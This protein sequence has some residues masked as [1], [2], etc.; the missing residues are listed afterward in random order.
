MTRRAKRHQDGEAFFW[1]DCQILPEIPLPEREFQF[2]KPRRWRFDFAWPK[3]MLAV[4]IEGG[5]WSQ[6][7]HTRGVGFV[8][9]CEKYNTATLMGWRVLRFPTQHATNGYASSVIAEVFNGFRKHETGKFK[10]EK[11]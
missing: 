2:A 3:Y 7:R 10:S 1:R 11:D 9:D 6:G 4:E 5:V 8:A